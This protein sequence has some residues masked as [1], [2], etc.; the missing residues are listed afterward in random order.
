MPDEF[1]LELKRFDPSD[2]RLG[3]HVAHDSRSLRFRAPA[4]DPR[5]LASVRHRVNIQILDQ[6]FVGSC[7]GHAGVAVLASDP[8]WPASEEILGRDRDPHL[9]AVDLYSEATKIDPWTGTYRPD[10]TGSDGLSVA[11]VLHAQGLISG[12]QHA[13]SLAAV[14]TALAERVVM[15]GSSWLEGMYDVAADGHM[16]VRGLSA[17]GHEYALDEIDVP[18]K[19]VWMR[20]SWGSSYGL[21]GR[22]WMTWDE[23]GRL[24]AD[25]G[26]CT[27]LVPLTEPAPV[28]VPVPAVPVRPF[29]SV[30]DR[31]LAA[32]LTR[33]IG[34][35]SCPEYVRKPGA[36]WLKTIPKE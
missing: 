6:G 11:K 19:R 21:E 5:K 12:Y 20:N 26:D 22:A 24:L 23:L 32:A 14:L 18:N 8:F 34:A 17:G 25:Q 33:F 13:T 27:V 29:P 30:D 35:R 15:I 28:P 3:R 7:T 16:D 4:R 2:R 1:T 36:A 10:D 31:L 9:A